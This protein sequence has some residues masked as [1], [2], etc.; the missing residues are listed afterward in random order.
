MEIGQLYQFV[1][2]LVLVGIVIGIGTLV[3]YKMGGVS[4]LSSTAST[5]INATGA[6]VSGIAT[7]WLPI[8]VVVVVAAVILGLVMSSFGQRR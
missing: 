4:G 2:L 6:E 3:L 8:I 5:A 7:N 1:L